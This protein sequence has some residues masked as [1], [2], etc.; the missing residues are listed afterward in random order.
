MITDLDKYI[1]LLIKVLEG[2]QSPSNNVNEGE[3][4]ELESLTSEILHELVVNPGGVIFTE[5]SKA[6]KQSYKAAISFFYKSFNSDEFSDLFLEKQDE[7][8]ELFEYENRLSSLRPTFINIHPT[9]QKQFYSFYNESMRCWLF[10]LDI[11]SVIVIST[12]LENILK[13][14]LN[15]NSGLEILINDSFSK[16]IISS[17]S[18]TNSHMLRKTR[19]KI[20]HEGYIVNRNESLQLITKTKEIIEDIYSD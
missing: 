6:K 4:A 20:V 17:T 1:E 14:A 13:S 7:L 9:N 15:S 10:G 16:G 3:K 12:L 19:N 18:K 11:S 2:L 5:N 8:S